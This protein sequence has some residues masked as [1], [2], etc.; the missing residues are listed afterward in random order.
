MR[1]V[2]SRNKYISICLAL[3]LVF[4][5]SFSTAFDAHADGGLVPMHV[6]NNTNSTAYRR[7]YIIKKDAGYEVVVAPNNGENKVYI[8]DYDSNFNITSRTSIDFELPLFGGFYEGSDAYYL[9]FGQMNEEQN[10]DKEILRIVKYT[11]KWERVSSCSVKGNYEE[12]WENVVMSFKEGM[13]SP[14]DRFGLDALEV[15]GYLY[16]FTAVKGYYDPSVENCHNGYLALQINKD[17]MELVGN[18]FAGGTHTNSLNLAATDKDNIYF[19]EKC[20]D[21]V[22]SITKISEDHFF[23]SIISNSINIYDF[24]V[25]YGLSEQVVNPRGIAVAG[26]NIITVGSTAMTSGNHQF[27]EEAFGI[28]VTKTPTADFSEEST[29]FKMLKSNTSYI[30]DM[31]FLKINDNKMLLIWKEYNETTGTELANS[32]YFSTHKFHYMF[33]DSEGNQ[34]G[35]EHVVDGTLSDCKVLL[36]GSNLVFYASESHATT[37]YTINLETNECSKKTYQMITDTISWK[38]ENG[39]LTLSGTG[40]LT[41]LFSDTLANNTTDIVVEEGITEFD[42][43][44]FSSYSHVNSIT[45]PDEITYMGTRCI[46]DGKNC[47]TIRCSSKSPAYAY[48]KEHYIKYELTDG[49]EDEEDNSASDNVEDGSSSESG[50]GS[51]GSSESACSGDRYSNE[52]RDGK[53]YNADGSQTYEPVLS[54]HCNGKGWWIQDSSGWY[55]VSKW[56]KING[57]W[58]Y[59]DAS[60]YMASSEW[61]DGW[62]CNGDGSCT[63][64]GQGSW[65]SDGTGWWYQDSNN[66]YPCNMWQKING[67][68]YYFKGDGYMATNQYIDGYWVGANGECSN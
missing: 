45:L 50:N 29:S 7:S 31:Q 13:S 28:Y 44:C 2:E 25:T 33:I 39:V 10:D 61:V 34:I 15:N 41:N 60:G 18:S 40:R 21:S 1:I 57:I 36:D 16:L 6:S 27:E 46:P 52:W 22:V 66:W 26:S 35:E 55:P 51:G 58:Y 47:P 67:N 5:L 23:D 64:G 49:A 42:D 9:F 65:R 37:F 4:A 3:F 63:Y 43:F 53:W 32:D 59:F 12:Y 11:K 38:L 56:Q 19:L 24:R 14:F 68:W 8:E 62:W 54:W 17:N 30:R 48:V 20:V